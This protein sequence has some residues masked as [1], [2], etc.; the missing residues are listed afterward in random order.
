M[1]LFSVSDKPINLSTFKIEFD[2]G[3]GIN[4]FEHIETLNMDID[5]TEFINFLFNTDWS[6]LGEQN[7]NE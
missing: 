4:V 1:T 6:K 5:K 2:K 7:V 3:E